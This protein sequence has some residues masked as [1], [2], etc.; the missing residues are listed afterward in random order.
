MKRLHKWWKLALTLVALV[1][2]AQIT[3]S[4][5]VRTRRVHEYLIAHLER[6]F[7]RTVEVSQFEA[8]ILPTPR[9]DANGITVG[10][11]PAFGNEYF[12][13]AEHLAASLRWRGLL[14][15][16]FEFGTLSFTRPSLILVRSAQGRWNLERWLPPAKSN[17][18]EGS[19]QY[20]P[21]AAVALANRLQR[22]EFDDGRINFKNVD[23]KLAFAF[24]AVSGNVEQVS[25]GRWKLQLEAQ[26]WRSGVAL[27]STGTVRVQ[28]DVAG[29][30]ARLQPAEIAVHWDEASLADLFRLV[31]GRDYGVR[32]TFGLEATAKIGAV[33]IAA[34]SGNAQTTVAAQIPGEWTFSVQARAA[35]I[36]RWDMTERSDNPQ[37]NARIK[38]RWN[39]ISGSVDAN[40]VILDTRKS[41]LRGTGTYAG[42]E[43]PDFEVRLDSAGIQA[44]DLLAWYRAFQ[45]DVAE[46]LAAEQYFTGA[47][48]LHGWPLELEDAAF[49]S[50]GGE[51]RFPGMTQ[52]LRIG[53]VQG[54]RVRTKFV[55]EPVHVSLGGETKAIAPAASKR[56]GVAPV[57]NAADISFSHDFSTRAGNVS[58]DGRIDKIETALKMAAAL[59]RPLN[60]GWELT[61]EAVAATQWQWASPLAGRWNGKILVNHGA[62]AIAG[63]NLPVK[64]EEGLLQWTDGIHSA[65]LLKVDALGAGWTGNIR[66]IRSGQVENSSDWKFQLD[67]DHLDAADLDRWVGP[68]ARPGWLQ[69]LLPSLL[70]GSSSAPVVPASELLRRVNADGEL[71]IG[72]LTVEKLKLS[73]VHAEGSLRELKLDLKN[74]DAEWAGGTVHAQMQA[75]FSPKPTYDVDAAWENINLAQIPG[76]GHAADHL[77]GAAFGKVHLTT[78]GVGRD[79]LLQKL[80]GKGSLHLNKVELRGWDLSASVAD[81]VARTGASR[82]TTGEGIFSLRDRSF[83]L[84]NLRLDAG[85]EQTFIKGVITF[86]QD[87]NLSIHTNATAKPKDHRA[88]LAVT[89]HI[90]KVSGPLDG[91]QVSL[92]NATVQPTVD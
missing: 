87:A 84:E 2:I 62:L 14:L 53:P 75:S 51:I 10:E 39:V 49:S 65:Q 50:H 23:D 36:H 72:Q 88:K 47:I 38:G 32:G 31:G 37:I 67:A 20:G 6:A 73:N 12:L 92:E 44:T 52:P 89:S 1:V 28:G 9:L 27:Q 5:L 57:E 34:N 18:S 43:K 68:R 8:Q 30:S 45:P 25:S 17:V 4:I 16:R 86:G 66:E 11:D 33:G 41:N 74:A 19:Q 29:T 54:G 64:V 24:T 60:H 85:K 40:E 58:I 35:Q 76:T 42:L 69:R 26:P 63:L 70:G 7:G 56:R 83:S 82:W 79:E 78:A 81:G 3:V 55:V 46:G 59:G 21:P 61:G 48:H 90:L 15:G 13:R 22:I 71:H 91:P 77:G 80:A